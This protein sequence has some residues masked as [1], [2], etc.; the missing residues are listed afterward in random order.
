MATKT[1]V[2]TARDLNLLTEL[3]EVGIL[4]SALLVAR[5][6][7]GFGKP[8]DA[9][10][11]FRRRLRILR[12]AGWIDSAKL[13]VPHRTGSSALAVHSLT[14][15]GA[16]L[17]QTLTG[18]CPRRAGASLELSPITLPHRLGVI[19]T[20]LVFDDA[21]R[22]AGLS[23]PDW[24][25][26]Y[27]L[28]SGVDPRGS[29]QEKFVLYEAFERGG[30]RL[31]CWADAAARITLPHEPGQHLV[32]YLEYDRSTETAKQLAAKAEPF[33]LLVRERR[34]QQHWPNLAS[35]VTVRVLFVCRSHQRV[36]NAID[37]IRPEPGA[38]L[39]RFAT[40]DDLKPSTLL[41]EPIWR[42]TAGELRAIIRR[43]P[44][45]AS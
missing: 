2:P 45:Q 21:H 41:T 19:A 36:A 4:S 14:A 42:T 6:F 30:R 22:A 28:R 25:H 35:H 13:A 33:D 34:Y 1:F 31:V 26:E 7:P 17:V 24:I 15:A 12:Q 37:A 11:A 10:R 8:A 43:T 18:V 3:G 39:F 40:Y 5:H 38:E 29:N 27:D 16:E 20:R 23:V 44:D 9:E 32:V